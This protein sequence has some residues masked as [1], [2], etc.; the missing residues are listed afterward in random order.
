ASGWIGPN[1]AATI[2]R[3]VAPGGVGRFNFKVK[4]PATPGTYTQYFGLVEEGVRWFAD[5]GGPADNVIWVRVVSVVPDYRAELV[6]AYGWPG[7]AK[8]QLTAGTEATGYFEVKN[9]GSKTW[10]ANSTNLGTSKPRD[11]ASA[12]AGSGWSGLNRPATIDRTV[13]PG[14]TGRFRFTVRAP[15]TPGVYREHF[16]LVQE[17]VTWFSDSGGPADDA[18]LLEV[19]SVAP[20]PDA[21]TPPDAGLLAD[22]GVPPADA[23][24]ALDAGLVPFDAGESWDAG[25]APPDAG[26]AADGGVTSGED[27]STAPDAGAVGADG[28]SDPR[29]EPRP[30]A[31]TRADAAEAPEAPADDADA[32][33]EGGCACGTPAP[34]L[35]AGWLLL[36]AAHLVARI[37]RRAR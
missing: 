4:A 37:R 13:A 2:D 6:G 28:G 31:G 33:I 1:R 16:N 29:D 34:G 5:S 35:S 7:G 24:L 9:T 22:A 30:D 21:G 17:G 25:V 26:E 3:Q 19:T 12:V 8:L 20:P 27:A 36:G 10:Y 11:R 32:V 15:N 14:A 23:G 18:L